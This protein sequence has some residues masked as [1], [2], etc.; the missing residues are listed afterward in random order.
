MPVFAEMVLSNEL[1]I[2]EVLSK[3]LVEVATTVVKMVPPK[4]RCSSG[5]D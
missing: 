1:L 2:R 4:T 3:I 5:G